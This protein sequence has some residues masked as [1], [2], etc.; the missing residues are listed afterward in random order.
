MSNLDDD[1]RARANR[2]KAQSGPIVPVA[3]PQAETAAE[4]DVGAFLL[5]FLRPQLAFFLGAIAL[6]LGRGF[7]MKYLG[8]E[9]SG[10]LL[11]I[12]EGAV[13]LVLLVGLGLAFGRSNIISHCALLAGAALAFLTEGFYIPLMPDLMGMIYNPDYVAIVVLNA[14]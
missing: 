4:V 11:S 5:A 14:G 13:V 3:R 10:E 1:F 8:I 12:A 7:A 6:V 2:I 9:P